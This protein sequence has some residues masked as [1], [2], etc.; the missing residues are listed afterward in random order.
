MGVTPDIP[1]SRCV[2]ADSLTL[3]GGQD[4]RVCT[5]SVAIVEREL[6]P[7]RAFRLTYTQVVRLG[8]KC[9]HLPSH[10]LAACLFLIIV[11]DGEFC[12]VNFTFRDLCS[13]DLLFTS[14]SQPAFLY[15][16]MI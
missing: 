3:M 7:S 16:C 4:I 11:I 15:D 10:L 9:L 5:E 8:N 1:R 12:Q 14:A 13:F 6:F 2:T